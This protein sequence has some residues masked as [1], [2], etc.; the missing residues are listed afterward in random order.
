MCETI[1]HIYYNFADGFAM[2][3]I[4]RNEASVIWV[5]RIWIAMLTVSVALIVAVKV[6]TQ[7]VLQFNDN[8]VLLSC[9]QVVMINK[10]GDESGSVCTFRGVLLMMVGCFYFSSTGAHTNNTAI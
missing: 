4:G 6:S 7:I 8:F 1:K 5:M 2:V 10:H 9:W 3:T